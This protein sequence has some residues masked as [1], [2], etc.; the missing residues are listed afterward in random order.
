MTSA[1]PP[2]FWQNSV[3]LGAYVS[4][5]RGLYMISMTHYDVLSLIFKLFEFDFI[6]KSIEFSSLLFSFEHS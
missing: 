6:F 4:L 5:V 2:A 1:S 3:T